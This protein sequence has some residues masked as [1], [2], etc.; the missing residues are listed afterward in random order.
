MTFKTTTF[1]EHITEALGL[2]G[3]EDPKEVF[4]EDSELF[5]S[6][7]VSISDSDAFGKEITVYAVITTADG[8]VITGEPTVITIPELQ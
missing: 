6:K 3:F 5:A 8:T 7:K 1:Y 4:T 2:E